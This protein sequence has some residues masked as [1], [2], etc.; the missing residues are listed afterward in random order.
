MI[1]LNP[2]FQPG[3]TV[4]DLVSEKVLHQECSE[5]FRVGKDQDKEGKALRLH[6]HQENA[7]RAALKGA[8]YVLTTGTGSGKSLAYIVPIVD[9]VLR[10]GSGHGVQAIIVCPMN[11]LANSQFGELD[12]F[13]NAGY[14]DQKGPIR[15]RRYTGQEK[16]E[17]KEAILADPPDIILTNYVM[18]EL[19][20]TR[21]RD[22]KLVESAKDLQFLV[23]DEL[24]T[25]RGR[26]GAD[27]SLLVRRVREAT[28]E[29]KLRCVGTSAT[30]AGTG[31]F[32]KQQQQVAEVSST[33]F[34]T[35]VKPENVIGETLKRVTPELDFSDNVSRERLKQSVGDPDRAFPKDFKSFASDPLSSWIESTFGVTKEEES[36]RLIRSQPKTILG[37]QGAARELS[38]LTS[39]TEQH[40]TDVIQRA[41]LASYGI[42]PD[43]ET[44][45]QPFAF[46]LHQF[47]SRGDTVFATIEPEDQR[48]IT[49]VCRQRK[50]DKMARCLRDTWGRCWSG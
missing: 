33:I 3:V 1:Q 4:D 16:D 43:P 25:Y 37:E 29:D 17:E 7:I 50:W 38:E 34:G 47:I 6:K 18:L 9:Y 13:V 11:A 31:T 14:P 45:F 5:I 23:L 24:H 20:L 46:K 21:P 39:I 42:E 30:L 36:D 27:V 41:L 26:Q 2:S 22:R 15:F 10:K 28:S 40:A 19:I 49:V 48:Y 12:K 8:N 44:G 32:E 35:T